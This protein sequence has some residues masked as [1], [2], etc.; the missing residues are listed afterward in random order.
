MK[1][2]SLL[3]VFL[4]WNVS[5]FAQLNTNSLDIPKVIPPSPNAAAL[6]KYGDVPVGLY[7]GVPNISIPLYTV[8]FGKFSF[9]ISLSYFAGGLRVTELASQV[10]L[11]WSLNA[12]GVV[13]RSVNVKPDELGYMSHGRWADI[14]TLIKQGSLVQQA[15]GGS[16]DLVPDNFSFNF[17]GRS[18]KF[19]IDATAEN[20][21]HLIPFQPLQITYPRYLDSIQIVDENGII[22]RF[23]TSEISYTEGSGLD[24]P[25]T[26]SWYLTRIIT[27]Y[28][29]AEFTY[30]T[31]IEDIVSEQKSE[32]DYTKLDG[33]CD[34]VN[35]GQPPIAQVRAGVKVLKSIVTP[36]GT[37]NFYSAA[38]RSDALYR[39]KLD[40]MVVLDLKGNRIK[41][42]GLNYSY[43]GSVTSSSIKARRLK[44][45]SLSEEGATS[46]VIRWH[47]FDYLSPASVP[48]T[49]SKSQDIWGFYNGKGNLKL[50]PALDTYWGQRHIILQGADRDPD[51]GKAQVGMLTKITYP[52]GGATE[53][54]YEGNDF[55]YRK[56]KVV[57][58]RL[59]IYSSQYV[60]ARSQPGKPT[61]LLDEY[62]EF[63]VPFLQDVSIDYSGTNNGLTSPDGNPSVYLYKVGP[64]SSLTLLWQKG[65][66][67]TGF[68][69]LM[70][71]DS[72][73]Y[74]IRAV[75][76]DFVTSTQLANISATWYNW[77]DTL[78]VN[79]T[80]GI[81]I[82]EIITT[83]RLNPT[84]QVRRFIYRDL[85]D[86]RRSSGNIVS[87]FSFV[88]TKTTYPG[89]KGCKFL[90]RSSF[91]I[92]TT[93]T[94]H[95]SN[96]GYAYVKELVNDSASGAKVSAFSQGNPNGSLQ[97]Y[98]GAPMN[99]F[100][101]PVQKSDKYAQDY[102]YFRGSLLSET[103]LDSTGRSLS[104]TDIIYNF[105]SLS[106]GNYYVAK[107]IYGYTFPTVNQIL[108]GQLDCTREPSVLGWRLIPTAIEC[109]WI[110]EVQRKET[111]Y[112]TP[113]DSALVRLV[114]SY[115]ENPSHAQLTRQTE[116][117]SD[118]KTA[119]S[120]FKYPLDF[121][122]PANPSDPDAAGIKYL[123]DKHVIGSVIEKYTTGDYAT[124]ISG[125]IITY[126]AD[127]PFP[128][129]VWGY[130]PDGSLTGYVPARI[131]NGLL[132]KDS[133]YK[134]RVSFD[135]Y[136]SSGNIL[137]QG[138]V[139]DA[140]EI[141]LWG[142]N[143]QY[144][145]ASV[146][147]ANYATVASIVNKD[148][149]RAPVSPQALRDELN[150]LRINLPSALV[151]TYTYIPLIGVSSETDPAG[152]TT[153]FE[154][155]VFGRLK[156]VKD[157]DGKILK[158]IDY[159]YKASIN[160]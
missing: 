135:Q 79:P 104:R 114:K 49:D 136:D 160:R 7:T 80:G 147:G 21:A 91:P 34:D 59:K 126:N 68:S 111:F 53:F 132:L 8:S 40:S 13:T 106:N 69:T 158:Q 60:T 52:T 6:G 17:A 141:Y 46:A 100:L 119:T 71:L 76:D 48:P 38:N 143:N 116:I 103:Y 55:G 56:T 3:L 41:K 96:V 29:N 14:D 4:V 66:L 98:V 24:G 152:R 142:Y 94:T 27:P 125:A 44:L 107:A 155:D 127:K 86:P 26:S 64:N 121:S 16:L 73:L 153:Y 102:D 144:P 77:G 50:L 154:Y 92:S 88:E 61:G 150:K 30:S 139:F 131:N 84:P 74:R 25:Y 110:Y 101:T 118:G 15:V 129:S 54:V 22:Y 89:A 148:I 23:S 123:Q 149:L 99:D 18:G 85:T 108:C 145:V 1:R 2:L 75:V 51:A 5:L 28:G 95:G 57:N 83:D 19:I 20:K 12:G 32:L 36:S 151:T 11:G 93:S 78:R 130:E 31:D 65:T 117:K 120:Y 9:P 97:E 81:R 137:Q 37:I 63:V 105:D 134:Q 62:S 140:P 124:D 39:S 35:G 112:G 133:R 115:Y 146:V 43:F 109:P 87:D 128:K 113:G 157:R 122:L 156:L 82:K 138:K 42:I 58:D 72:G 159:Q 33:L 45:D 47:T 67:M 70:S 10:G 90:I